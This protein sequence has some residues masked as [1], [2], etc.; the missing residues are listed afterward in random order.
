MGRRCRGRNRTVGVRVPEE[1][2]DA[3][4]AKL[5]GRPHVSFSCQFW[6]THPLP[7]LFKNIFHA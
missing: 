6:C 2:I 5:E 4:S 1:Q 7:L 3:V